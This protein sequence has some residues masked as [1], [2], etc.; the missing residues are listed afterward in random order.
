[1]INK[2]SILLVDDDPVFH[3]INTK[4]LQNLGFT[5]I[6][7]AENGE[8]ALNLIE[9]NLSEARSIPDAIF[10]DLNMP[11][12]DGFGFIEAFKKL[13]IPG[14]SK[15]SIAILTSSSSSHDKERAKELGVNHYYTKPISENTLLEVLESFGK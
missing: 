6:I 4:I 1:M 12:L 13:A 14:N 2:L 11:I 15:V 3:F 8:V 5:R 9:N 10:V 7:S